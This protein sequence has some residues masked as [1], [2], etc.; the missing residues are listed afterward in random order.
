MHSPFAVFAGA[1]SALLFAATGFAQTKVEFARDI[2]PIFRQNCYG[3]HGPAMANAGLRMDRKSSV[4]RDQLR[5]V[6]PGSSQNS[7]LLH[8]L[9]GGEYGTPMPPT[10]PLKK[11][12]VAMVKTWIDQGAPWP[13]NLSNETTPP[14]PNRKA[15][16]AVESLRTANRDAFLRAIAA[17][18]QL[19]NA[20]GPE[21]S[22]PFMYAVL[23][24]DAAFLE[25]LIRR[26]A[27][28]NVKNDAGATPLMWAA[29]NP[30]KARTLLA[31]GAEV[32]AISDDLR[33]PL[34]IAA[35]SPSGR[36]A[37]KLLLD[38]GANVN[39]TKHPE[40]DSSPLIQAAL[41]A[42]AVMMQM[43][44]DRG[45]DV[46]ASA[47]PALTFAYQENCGKCVDLLMRRQLP[48]EAYTG[49]LQ[50]NV[51]FLDATQVKELLDHGA[52]ADAPDTFGRTPLANAAGS[53][54]IP[55]DVVNLLIA[56]GANVNAKSL[57]K[58]SADAGLTV[59]DIARQ[60]GDTRIVAA[61]V[62]AGAKPAVMPEPGQKPAGADSARTAITRALP[63]LQKGDAGFTT[64]AGCISCHNDSMAAMAVGAARSHGFSVNEQLS[65]QQV[66]ANVMNLEHLRDALHQVD[67]GIGIGADFFYPFVL[68]Y[69]LIGLAAEKHPAD[70]NTDAAAMYLLARQSADGSW[71]FS[72]ADGR[73]PI[74]SV[75]IGQTALA[76]RGLQLYGL[77]TDKAANDRAI[78]LAGAWI[79][80]AEP[81]T[82]E[83]YIWK[84]MGLSWAGRDVAA[85]LKARQALSALQRPDGG[86]GDLTTLPP[87]VYTTAHALVALHGAGLAGT[88]TVWH[89]GV[90]FLL[91]NQQGDGSWFVPTRALAVQPFF[92]AGFPHG[93]NQ[94]ISAAGSA[95]ATMALALDVS[96][97]EPSRGTH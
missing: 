9:E 73:P 49:A 53:D 55:V 22:T 6:V 37:A 1:V 89:N 77:K 13:D 30:E 42:D 11:E 97:S 67:P 40:G 38:K 87:S 56:H 35:S 3:C 43:L 78:A 20:R 76:M 72:R 88:D 31:H 84:A 83:D 58:A 79:A 95:W 46:N 24:T 4:F 52:E 75:Y 7:F 44:I 5:R 51:V 91:K 64:R 61:L 39:P 65:R 54:N 93:V 63:L 71:P 50:A 18:S 29:T 48:K 36:A 23:Y 8:R 12:Q 17:D 47:G 21:G 62:E 28:V 81:K 16:A 27:R 25:E 45:A 15:V 32:N 59:L 82:T 14:P 26:G 74:C 69:Q 33:T 96:S 41:S 86:W 57:H 68:G 60:Q 90:N 66:K 10:G 34:S 85:T 2:Q 80:L 19:L 92:D 94:W 70:L